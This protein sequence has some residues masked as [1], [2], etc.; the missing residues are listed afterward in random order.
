ML[1]DISFQS[2][3]GERFDSDQNE[4]VTAYLESQTTVVEVYGGVSLAEDPNDPT[5]A[6]NGWV[7]ET[8]GLATAAV[9][10]HHVNQMVGH[11]VRARA[12]KSDA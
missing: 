6:D 9:L 7:V 5:A 8:E 3:V 1:V 10:T 2:T 12:V 4:R 11:E